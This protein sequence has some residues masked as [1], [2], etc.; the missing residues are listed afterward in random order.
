ME[1]EDAGGAPGG[2]A[3]GVAVCS[4]LGQLERGFGL[5]AWLLMRREVCC[6]PA[7]PG[8]RTGS[9]GWALLAVPAGPLWVPGALP[10]LP[11][12]LG[13]SRWPPGADLCSGFLTQGPLLASSRLDGVVSRLQDRHAARWPGWTSVLPLVLP[14][15]GAVAFHRAVA[16][17]A[18]TAALLLQA[19]SR[20]GAH[21]RV[22]PGPRV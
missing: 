12:W 7:L 4:G 11:A 22:K 19:S 8:G 6:V 15:A 2:G 17:A 10:R 13:L 1:A 5:R 9:V 16:G 21:A 20:P 18:D 3:G 14:G